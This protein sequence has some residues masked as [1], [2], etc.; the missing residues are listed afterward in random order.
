MLHNSTN[1]GNVGWPSG[2]GIPGGQYDAFVCETCHINP[3][4][5]S[6]TNIKRIRTQIETPNTDTWPNGAQLTNTITL[7]QADGTNSDHG[8]FDAAGGWTGVCNVCHDDTKHTFYYWNGAGSH[9]PGVDCVSCHKHQ[10][11][12]V[13]DGPCM[14]C[15]DTTQG[16]RRQVVGAGGDFVRLSRHVNNGTATQI[17]TDYDCIVCHAE[18]DANKAEAATGYVNNQP[19]AD[20]NVDL[21]NVDDVN[22]GDT[23][24]TWDAS[25]SEATKNAGMRT[26]MDTFCLTC[27]DSDGASTIAVNGT[28][29]G[30]DLALTTSPTAGEALTPFNDDD[31]L[32]NGRD[33]FSTRTRVID[34]K[35]KFFAGSGG[36]GAGYNGNP[37]QHAVLGARYSTNNA[38]WTAAAWSTHDLRSGDVMNVVRETATLHCSDCHLSESNAHGASNAWHMLQDGTVDNYTNDSNMGGLQNS[39]NLNSNICYKCHNRSIYQDT[40]STVPRV[41]HDEDGDWYDSDYGGATEGAELGPVCLNCHAGD[42]F[43]NIH[44]VSGQYDPDNA[45]WPITGTQYTRYRFMPGAWMRWSPGGGTSSTA[46]GDD[47]DWEASSQNGTCYFPNSSSWSDCGQHNGTPGSAGAGN[48]TINYNRAV[49]Y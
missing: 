36:S 46:A 39:S 4:T 9:E 8:D 31:T 21:R 6:T 20:G 29:S 18:G 7:T 26:N 41:S 14:D 5:D 35:T 2:W 13:G 30:A 33:G 34:I 24:Y 17:V 3:A 45:T 44:G 49:V 32:E 25:A 23:T 43:G 28:V 27:H 47:S 12:F 15:H 10:V 22:I 1:V 16:S 48:V 40:G 19:H 37:S 38:G 11:A 42:N